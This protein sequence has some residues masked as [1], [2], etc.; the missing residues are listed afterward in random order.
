MFVYFWHSIMVV[1]GL[2]Q[3]ISYAANFMSVLLLSPSRI[4]RFLIFDIDSLSKTSRFVMVDEL[5]DA[6]DGT[7]NDDVDIDED[8][9]VD[10]REETV[11][12]G[13]REEPDT[14]TDEFA[15][16]AIVCIFFFAA[17]DLPCFVF[18][19]GLLTWFAMLASDSGFMDFDHMWCDASRGTYKKKKK[20]IF[21]R[22][23][24]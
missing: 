5:D 12:G 4:R 2:N 15:T 19:G 1:D 7:E 20:K 6:F 22:G 11:D 17:N 24:T 18:V 13:E 14:T 23:V 9:F 3:S 16:L 8:D 21:L 10:D